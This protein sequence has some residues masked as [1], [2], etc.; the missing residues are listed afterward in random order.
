MQCVAFRL[1]LTDEIIL[2]LRE[3]LQ[4]IKWPGVT[5]ASDANLAYS[6][7]LTEFNIIYNQI[8]PLTYCKLKC[9]SDFNK[10]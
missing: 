10:P 7:F 5:E 8:M 4:N 3:S 1:K 6:Q 2:L 9:Y